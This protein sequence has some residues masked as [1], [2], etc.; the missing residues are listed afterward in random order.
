M[1]PSF[2]AGISGTVDGRVAGWSTRRAECRSAGFR[3][4][5]FKERGRLAHIGQ[6]K[7]KGCEV[8]LHVAGASSRQAVCGA[9]RPADK[10]RMSTVNSEQRMANGE[11]RRRQRLLIFPLATRHSPDNPHPPTPKHLA[12]ALGRALLLL[13]AAARRSGSHRRR[14]AHHGRENGPG[15]Q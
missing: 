12:P 2:P 1:A 9:S 13:P 5:V 3:R 15:S 14:R 6:W 7:A 11:W 8:S 4:R 10:G